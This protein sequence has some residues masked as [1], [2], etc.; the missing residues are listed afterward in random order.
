MPA[1]IEF[2]PDFGIKL[3][4]EM[5]VVE[6]RQ[7]ARR[8]QFFPPLPQSWVQNRY[9]RRVSAWETACHR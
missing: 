3:G 5:G 2:E 7:S 4:D 8:D 1:G 6:E 9:I